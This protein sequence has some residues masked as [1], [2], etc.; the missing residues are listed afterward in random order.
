MKLEIS[1]TLTRA[2][3][4]LSTDMVEKDYFDHIDS[5]GRDP[6]NRMD[7]FGY[8]GATSSGENIAAGFSSA[9]ETFNQWKSSPAHNSNM[10]SSSYRTIGIGRASN[11]A[12]SYG[13]YWTT[14]FGSKTNTTSP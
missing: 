12:S 3:D 6:F 10:L 2:S 1:V 4:W 8:L 11:E 13:W 9:Q 7:D 14:D 5:Q